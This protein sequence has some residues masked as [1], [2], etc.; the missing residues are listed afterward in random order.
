MGL[1]RSLVSTGSELFQP[2]GNGEGIRLMSATSLKQNPPSSKKVRDG[3][4]IIS[5]NTSNLQDTERNSGRA[6]LITL[7]T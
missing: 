7:W 5:A 2:A 6:G 1:L 3:S 4:I